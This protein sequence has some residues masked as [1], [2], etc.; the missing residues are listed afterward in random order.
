MHGEQFIKGLRQTSFSNA[1]FQKKSISIVMFMI[2]I[3]SVN[4]AVGVMPEF[5]SAFQ[6]RTGSPMV[7]PEAQKVPKIF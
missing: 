7:T 6:C 2:L 1:V 5:S 4:G 3:C